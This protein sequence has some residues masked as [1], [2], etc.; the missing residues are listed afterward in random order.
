L[1]WRRKENFGDLGA[2]GMIILI[3]IKEIGLDDLRRVPVILDRE[4]W[5]AVFKR[6]MNI[7]VV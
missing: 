6:V 3:K 5:V 2:P 1:N 4:M 7:C